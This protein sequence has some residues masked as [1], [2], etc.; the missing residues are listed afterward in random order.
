MYCNT[1]ITEYIICINTY[2]PNCNFVPCGHFTSSISASYCIH[3][4]YT[5]LIHKEQVCIDEDDPMTIIRK[6]LFANED[7]YILLLQKEKNPD[8]RN[9]KYHRNIGKVKWS[10]ITV[11]VQISYM[12]NTSILIITCST[13]LRS[14]LLCMNSVNCYQNKHIIEF[15]DISI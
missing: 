4:Q 12:N 13:P 5:K 1:F 2:K 15:H 6:Y 14:H 8:A 10:P 7:W 9:R 11:C 3:I